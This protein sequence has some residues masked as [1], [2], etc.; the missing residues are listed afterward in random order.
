MITFEEYLR[1]YL[2]K[3]IIDHSIRVCYDENMKPQFYIH[4]VGHN[5]MTLDFKVDGNNLIPIGG[6]GSGDNI[7]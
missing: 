1:E 3:N 5:S 2:N 4:A 7:E 6:K